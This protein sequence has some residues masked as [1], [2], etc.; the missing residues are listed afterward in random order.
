M[1]TPAAP[2]IR[3]LQFLRGKPLALPDGGPNPELTGTLAALAV[4]EFEKAELAPQELSSFI[5][6]LKQVLALS[7]ETAPDDRYA[8]ACDEALD[9]IA[10]LLQKQ[11]NALMEE[12]AGQFTPL[13]TTTADLDAVLQHLKSALA[14][15]T[16]VLVRK[17]A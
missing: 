12:W 2:A 9:L 13:I 6:A 4:R 17:S 5:E 11:P 7:G 1:P 14:L 10:R 8:A 3:P 16:L 15:Y